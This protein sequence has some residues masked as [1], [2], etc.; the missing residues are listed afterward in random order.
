MKE[1]GYMWD[2]MFSSV[3]LLQKGANASW[4]RNEVLSNNIANKDT[5]GFK[6][7]DVEFESII[8]KEFKLSGSR[9][10]VDDIEAVVV[11]DLSDQLTMDGNNVDIE[12]EM[13]EL[14]RNTIEYYTYINKIN[15]EFRKLDSAIKVV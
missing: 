9:A 14:A 8:N 1:L 6:R 10:A 7:S 13:V 4:L 3:N 2:T 12:K 15:S 5:P 11:T